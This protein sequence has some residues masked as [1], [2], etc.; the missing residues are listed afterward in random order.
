MR[1]KIKISQVTEEGSTLKA[2][3]ALGIILLGMIIT[4]KTTSGLPRGWR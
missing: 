4:F 2:M 1:G 3:A